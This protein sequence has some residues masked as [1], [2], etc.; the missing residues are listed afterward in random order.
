MGQQIVLSV[1][2]PQQLDRMSQLWRFIAEFAG[3]S[4][5]E[6]IPPPGP[7]ELPTSL[8]F[9]DGATVVRVGPL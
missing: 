9:P 1:E 3:D 5:T 2:L 7:D 6:Q 4:P 8:S